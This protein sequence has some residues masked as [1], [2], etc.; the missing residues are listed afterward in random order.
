MKCR[1][2]GAEGPE[3][4]LIQMLLCKEINNRFLVKKK[5]WQGNN[6]IEKNQQNDKI[7]QKVLQPTNNI[8]N[9]AQPSLLPCTRRVQISVS[10]LSRYVFE[11][12]DCIDKLTSVYKFGQQ[13]FGFLEGMQGKCKVLADYQIQNENYPLLS[14]KPTLRY[15]QQ[16]HLL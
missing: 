16:I 3:S 14:D 1:D 8:S 15:V 7:T 13:N 9:I 5:L 11:N 4:V 12:T 10:S 6:G 2:P